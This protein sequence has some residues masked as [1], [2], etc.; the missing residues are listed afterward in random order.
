MKKK[1]IYNKKW[2][3]SYYGS[4]FEDNV[5]NI[6]FHFYLSRKS[7]YDQ[8]IFFMLSLLGKLDED[9]NADT[10]TGGRKGETKGEL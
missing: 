1:Y 8:G 5:L 9:P 6:Y 10:H 3:Q 4:S 2:D 7:H